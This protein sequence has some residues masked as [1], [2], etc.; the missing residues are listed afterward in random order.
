MG[1][2][3]IPAKLVAGDALSAGTPCVISETVYM[4]VIGIQR[5]CNH[6]AFRYSSQSIVQSEDYYWDRVTGI[7]V[8]SASSF[9][10]GS[11]SF[12]TTF[13]ITSSNLFPAGYGAMGALVVVVAGGAAGVIFVVTLV[14]T[15]RSRRGNP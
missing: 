1:Y 10:S 13:N 5:S 8:Q 7:L 14:V 6:L 12:S 3:V 11:D 15:V 9:I 2:K 4:T